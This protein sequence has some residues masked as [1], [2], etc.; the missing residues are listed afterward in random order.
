MITHIFSVWVCFLLEKLIE[1]TA[2]TWTTIL[3]KCS[4]FEGA[5]IWLFIGFMLAFGSLI[6]SMWILF[7]GYVAKGKR[8]HSLYFTSVGYWNGALKLVLF[9]VSFFLIARPAASN[10][11]M[12]RNSP[13]PISI[14]FCLDVFSILEG[15]GHSLLFFGFQKP[16]KQNIYVLQLLGRFWFAEK[17]PYKALIS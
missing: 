2:A 15:M 4:F 16:Q 13:L 7:G 14:L 5:R 10:T 12:P 9:F 17:Y 11:F 3:V 1:Q 8:E 6:A